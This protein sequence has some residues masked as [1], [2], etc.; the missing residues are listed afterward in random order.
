MI[1][2][3]LRLTIFTNIHLQ[4]CVMSVYTKSVTLNNVWDNLSLASAKEKPAN[5]SNSGLHHE[6]TLTS[7][8]SILTFE[9]QAITD[10]NDA[11]IFDF[12][13]LQ[14][15]ISLPSLSILPGLSLYKMDNRILE[16]YELSYTTRTNCQIFL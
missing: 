2:H 8:P 3:F 6:I 4:E 7:S 9:T 11:A 12:N 10:E 5:H 16:F 13:K 15:I 1:L 14:P